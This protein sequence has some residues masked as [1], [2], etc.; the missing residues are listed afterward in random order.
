MILQKQ[1][2]AQAEDVAAFNGK[3]GSRCGCM[4]FI[5]LE[6]D[7]MKGVLFFYEKIKE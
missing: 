2:R 6:W 3:L 1:L 4:K 7:I 5:P